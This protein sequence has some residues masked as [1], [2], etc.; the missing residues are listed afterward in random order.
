MKKLLYVSL[1][2]GVTNTVP[3]VSIAQA[4]QVENA[5]PIVFG[6]SDPENAPTSASFDTH[7]GAQNF[8]REPNR[9]VGT[10]S[11][12]G[13]VAQHDVSLNFQNFSVPLTIHTWA[14]DAKVQVNAQLWSVS[15]RSTDIRRIDK[16]N[17]SSSQRDIVGAIIAAR[18]IAEASG[19]SCPTFI[20]TKMRQKY[21]TLSCNL[22]K[23]TDFF[24]LSRDAMTSY[25]SSKSSGKLEA[26]ACLREVQGRSLSKLNRRLERRMRKNDLSKNEVVDV[27]ELKDA[28]ITLSNDPTWA[29]GASL[30]GLELDTL[31]AYDAKLTYRESILAAR[32]N[33]FSEAL[34]FNE[35]LQSQL[36]EDGGRKILRKV[37]INENLLTNDAAYFETKIDQASR[38]ATLEAAAAAEVTM[39]SDSGV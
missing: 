34:K 8:D 2:L 22:A 39:N 6:W 3:M 37:S 32:S 26:D 7:S 35:T 38:Q 27:R 23:K 1:V 31:A 12:S 25:A 28:L 33:Q 19:P 29:P 16:V 36:E 5:V 13:P 17:S 4:Q 18:Y 9:L 15:C 14:D 11:V 20:K 30:A 24:G 10:R 21:F